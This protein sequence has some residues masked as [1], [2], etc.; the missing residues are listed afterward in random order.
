MSS[1]AQGRC[2][3]FTTGRGASG[4]ILHGAV[5]I[6]TEVRRFPFPQGSQSFAIS[7]FFH[8]P[9]DKRSAI[10]WTELHKTKF[11]T[12]RDSAGMAELPSAGK[13]EGKPAMG[14]ESVAPQCADSLS[15]SPHPRR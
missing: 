3:S 2:L 15:D 4:D 8:Y 6:L 9:L 12:T 14:W 5:L 1:P 11:P 7:Q 13:A 10:N